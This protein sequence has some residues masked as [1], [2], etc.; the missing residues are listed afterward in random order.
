MVWDGY[1]GDAMPRLQRFLES[2]GALR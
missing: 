1:A 2:G